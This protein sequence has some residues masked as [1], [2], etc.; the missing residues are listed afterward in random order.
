MATE[1]RAPTLAE[2]FEE[3]ERVIQDRQYANFEDGIEGSTQNNRVHAS[4]FNPS[5][6]GEEW[7]CKLEIGTSISAHKA[8]L[9]ALEDRRKFESAKKEAEKAAA[10]KKKKEIKKLK[11][12]IKKLED[13]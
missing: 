13:S 12:K 4:G 8:E 1:L 5:W 2:L 7:S 10:K 9:E 6:N 11:Q 3:I